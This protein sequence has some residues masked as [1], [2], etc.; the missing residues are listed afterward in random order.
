MVKHNSLPLFQ[1]LNQILLANVIH[2]INMIS[3]ITATFSQRHES[4]LS[5]MQL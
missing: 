2:D 3:S 4:N 1:L 5:K